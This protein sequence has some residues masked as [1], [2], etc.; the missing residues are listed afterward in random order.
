M[1]KLS[2]HLKASSTINENQR[3]VK[4]DAKEVAKKTNKQTNKQK[5]VKFL[6]LCK[7]T[8]ILNLIKPIIIIETS[9]Y[10]MFNCFCS[11]KW[12]NFS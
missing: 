4:M 9:F 6:H 10:I 5:L 2:S 3:E 7:N 8:Q 11:R 1:P 12:L